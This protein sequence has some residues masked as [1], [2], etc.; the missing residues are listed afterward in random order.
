M[1]YN[2]IMD[3][4]TCNICGQ[5]KPLSDFSKTKQL[6]SGY[7]G[8]CKVCH[9]QSNKKYYS[10]PNNYIRQKE[11]AKNNP[12]SRKKSYKKH[13]I[14]KEYGLNWDQYLQLIKKFNNQ[15]GICGGKDHIDLSVDHNHVTGKV[16]GLLCNNCNNGLGRFKDSES[17][18]KKAID[19]L[20]KN[21]S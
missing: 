10:N 14:K 15:C 12:D 19:Y 9:N 17:L 5:T 3:T 13:R 4:K 8:H 2:I 11:W 16:R 1:W 6:K 7:K 18:L 20:N 21:E